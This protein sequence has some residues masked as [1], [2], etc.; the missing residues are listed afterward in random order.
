MEPHQLAS[1]IE[2]DACELVATLPDLPPARLAA[3][4]DAIERLRVVVTDE[5]AQVA[6]V[7]ALVVAQYRAGLA[8]LEGWAV[9]VAACHALARALAE[10]TAGHARA[11]AAVRFELETLLPSRDRAPSVAGPDVPVTALYR[12]T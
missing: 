3:L 10:P 1:A 11:L 12:R 2:A 7:L 5:P 4:A 9:V 6:A 8:V